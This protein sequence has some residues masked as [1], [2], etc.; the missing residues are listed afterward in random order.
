[1][2]TTPRSR[3]NGRKKELR[4]GE[5][6][7]S[8]PASMAALVVCSCKAVPTPRQKSYCRSNRSW[9]RALGVFNATSRTRTPPSRKAVATP[10]R[11]SRGMCRR[12][13][14]S[15]VSAMTAAVPVKLIACCPHSSPGGL[16]LFYQLVP[17][18]FGFLLVDLVDSFLCLP[19]DNPVILSGAQR[20]VV[21]A[22][23]QAA[24]KLPWPTG[25]LPQLVA[26]DEHRRAILHHLDRGVAAARFP[27]VHQAIL[28]VAV[29]FRAGAVSLGA[30]GLFAASGL[31]VVVG[32]QHTADVAARAGRNFFRDGF[33]QRL[34]NQLH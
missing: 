24:A 25:I 14:I 12:T 16:G 32:Q 2:P 13:T 4:M 8:A 3:H 27:I 34:G 21:L 20:S 29:V 33:G 31:I 19:H 10:S 11:V 1:M 22:Q 30:A 6:K 18:S 9:S 28:P 17:E 26:V 7:N 5:N 23:A 15:F